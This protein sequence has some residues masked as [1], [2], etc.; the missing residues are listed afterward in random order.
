MKSF[1][2]S[3]INWIL[4]GVIVLVLV[5]LVA[6]GVLY[7]SEESNQDKLA[8]T[9][10]EKEI[11]LTNLELN[12]VD[13]EAILAKALEDLDKMSSSFPVEMDDV[14]VMEFLID[15]ADETKV[16]ITL[17]AGKAAASNLAGV[18]YLSVPITATIDGTF[19]NVLNFIDRIES[20]KISTITIGNCTIQGTGADWSTSMSMTLMSRTSSD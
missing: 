8:D 5:G 12:A 1:V 3:N 16:E 9:K 2:I 13:E 19:N 7:M 15:L 17:K 6:L 20:G 14:D 11:E 18:S 4:T 10:V